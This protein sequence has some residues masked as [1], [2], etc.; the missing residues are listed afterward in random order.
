MFG[1]V[2][3][4]LLPLLHYRGSMAVFPLHC[5]S[6]GFILCPLDFLWGVAPFFP[7]S[8]AFFPTLKLCLRVGSCFV[9]HDLSRASSFP[10]LLLERSLYCLFCPWTTLGFFG[11]QYSR[12][13]SVL[14]SD[15]CTSCFVN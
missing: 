11:L 5:F 10:R 2:P 12:Y 13:I 1:P 14:V 8:A 3:V 9:S 4:F 6:S 15:F 7:Y